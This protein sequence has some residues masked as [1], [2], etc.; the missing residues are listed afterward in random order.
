MGVGVIGCYS[1]CLRGIYACL[2][3]VGGYVGAI[4][5]RTLAVGPGVVARPGVTVEHSLFRSF[6]CP[7]VY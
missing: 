3:R 5:L 6:R 4:A 2:S 1:L 7:L